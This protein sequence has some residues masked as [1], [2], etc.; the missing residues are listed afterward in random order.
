MKKAL[1]LVESGGRLKVPRSSEYLDVL[2]EA[3]YALL[4][5]VP[6]GCT[7]SY[8]DIAKVLG[9]SPRLVA[10][11]MKKNRNPIVI[12]CHRVVL[13]SGAL[14]GY[15]FRGRPNPMLKRALLLLEGVV[16]RDDER[17]SDEALECGR[18]ALGTL[19]RGDDE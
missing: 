9:L 4:Q 18:R 10:L 8:S 7:V 12:P 19:L 6:L 16:F 11:I 3:V 2:S 5:L 14:G 1:V 13:K 17:V 15:T